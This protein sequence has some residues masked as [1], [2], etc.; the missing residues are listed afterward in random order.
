MKRVRQKNK[1]FLAT[2]VSF[3]IIL[4][5]AYA[6]S[7]NLAEADFLCTSPHLE[8]PF[9]E[10]FLSSLKG[11]WD[12]LEWSDPSIIFIQEENLFGRLLPSSILNLFSFKKASSLRC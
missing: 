4:F 1:V 11:K 2:V 6:H 9:L 10:G 3:W 5:F 7:Y 8:N 12:L